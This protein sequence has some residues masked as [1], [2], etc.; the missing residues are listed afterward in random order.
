MRKVVPCRRF[1]QKWSAAA[2]IIYFLCTGD[3]GR[4]LNSLLSMKS[5]CDLQFVIS[6]PI[7]RIDVLNISCDYPWVNATR[8][9]P[10]LVNFDLNNIAW[11]CRVTEYWC[12]H[13]HFKDKMINGKSAWPLTN[14]H[15]HDMV[16]N[17]SKCHHQKYHQNA[18]WRHQMETF[19]A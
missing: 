8:H 19:S 6:N 11:C 17:L 15:F 7:I 4:C 10:R 2:A 1:Y 9:Q 3:F 13:W 5:G 12:F 14:G 16:G 18:W